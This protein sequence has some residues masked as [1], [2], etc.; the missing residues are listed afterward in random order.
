MYLRQCFSLPSACLSICFQ[1]YANNYVHALAELR[2]QRER[3]PAFTQF[4]QEVAA[5][6][7]RGLESLLISPIQRIPRYVLLL[8]ELDKVTLPGHPDKPLLKNAVDRMRTL[9]HYVNDQKREA[10]GQHHVAEI[11]ARLT[12]SSL[13]RGALKL[14]G[15]FEL[16]QPSRRLL[17]EGRLD[18]VRRGPEVKTRVF[19]LFN[20]I[21][22]K[23]TAAAAAAAAPAADAAA[24]AGAVHFR[25]LLTVDSSSLIR[26]GRSAAGSKVHAPAAS[27]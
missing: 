11:A 25:G 24:A 2:R 16:V 17:R 10:E 5:V 13:V 4:A 21:F 18:D 1:F 3:N 7:G 19:F 12:S 23:G 6:T 26:R 20:D 8:R 27:R 14:P 22:I 15:G 9:A